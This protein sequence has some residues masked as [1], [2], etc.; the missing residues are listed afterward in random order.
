MQQCRVLMSAVT[1][2]WVVPYISIMLFEVG[3]SDSSVIFIFHD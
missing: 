3:S 1:R 2:G